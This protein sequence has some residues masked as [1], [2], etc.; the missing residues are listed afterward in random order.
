MNARIAIFDDNPKRREGLQLLIDSLSEHEWVGSFEDC[1]NVLEDVSAS[2]PDLILMDIDM[3][4][5]NGIEGVGK[6][7]TVNSDVKVLMQ[8]VFEDDEKVFAAICAGADGY[9]LKQ[10]QPHKLL[11]AIDEVLEGG[12]P[13][14]PVIARKVLQLFSKQNK[15]LV[16]KDFDLT[17]RETEILEYLVKGFS[18]KMIAEACFISYPTVNTH[19]SKIYRKLQVESAAGAVSKAIREGLV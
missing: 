17:K 9:I 2:Q 13:M 19:I 14:T 8:T 4:K 7:R 10:E 5:V 16:K 3:P 11:E 6:I 1:S 12:A 18:Y 15:P